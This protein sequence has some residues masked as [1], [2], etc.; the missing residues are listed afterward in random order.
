M[1][2]IDQDASDFEVDPGIAPLV[3]KAK[4]LGHEY[5]HEW[6]YAL[7]C[8]SVFDRKMP[9]WWLEG[10]AQYVGWRSVIEGGLVPERDVLT[11][12]TRWTKGAP[13]KASLQQ[14][15]ADF[16]NDASPYSVVYFA[17]VLLMRLSS[18]SAFTTFCE[19]VG[20]GATWQ[21][22]F[23]LSFGLSLSDF[24]QRFDAYRDGL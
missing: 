11:L 6:Q 12:L 23:P 21:A 5:T 13:I 1:I 7:G 4:V 10:M 2:F 14:L 22:A 16:P 19:R 15:E 18:A 3:V 8:N 17:T 20:A 9:R 24:Y